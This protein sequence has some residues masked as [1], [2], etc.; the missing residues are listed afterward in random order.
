MV[1]DALPGSGAFAVAGPLALASLVLYIIAF[2]LGMGAIPWI[3]MS[4]VRQAAT[5]VY[6]SPRLAG[7]VLTLLDVVQIFPAKARG[8]AGSVAVMTGWTS[9]FVVTLTF[10]YL[11]NWSPMGKI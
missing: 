10:N 3:I 6:G 8:L 7:A 5:R 11:L 2:S 1:Q 4:E 9:S